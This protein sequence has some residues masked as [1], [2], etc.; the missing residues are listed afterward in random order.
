MSK[1]KYLGRILL[2]LGILILISS[3]LINNLQTEVYLTDMMME[4]AMVRTVEEPKETI[5]DYIIYIL[6]GLAAGMIISGSL[7]VYLE[8]LMFEQRPNIIRKLSNEEKMIYDLLNEKN[9]PMY[10]SKLV[11]ET[12]WSKVKMS[13]VIKKLE[14]KKLIEK[15][16]KG[17]TNKIKIK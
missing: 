2:T 12:G 3:V 16:Q 4:E 9:E 14:K 5:S 7:V 15:E 6:I 11:K 10:Q 1:T 13:R 17:M 8:E